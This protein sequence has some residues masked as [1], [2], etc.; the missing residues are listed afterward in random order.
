[1][2][3]ATVLPLQTMCDASEWHLA[4]FQP[5]LCYHARLLTCTP[6]MQH[7]GKTRLVSMAFYE[8]LVGTVHCTACMP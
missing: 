4:A 1:M 6:L 3:C 8:Q 5:A 7:S 2:P